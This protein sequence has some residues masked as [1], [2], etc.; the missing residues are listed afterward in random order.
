[1]Q[2]QTWWACQLSLKVDQEQRRQLL[3]EVG[4]EDIREQARLGSVALNHAGDWLNNA[5][6]KALRLHLRPAEFVL[7]AKYRLGMPVFDKEG[8]C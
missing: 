5:P 6:L 2:W 1:M 4:E 8:P 7:T 3:S